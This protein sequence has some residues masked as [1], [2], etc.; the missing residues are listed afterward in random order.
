LINHISKNTSEKKIRCSHNSNGNHK[1]SVEENQTEQLKAERVKCQM[2]PT[3][4]TVT[5]LAR[6]N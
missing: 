2:R 4:W 3:L 1:K 5:E 6:I